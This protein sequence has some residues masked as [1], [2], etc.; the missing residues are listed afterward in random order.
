[1]KNM[2]TVAIQLT[3]VSKKYEI[4][5]EKPT[6]VEKFVKGKNETFWA[7]KD[8]NLTIKKGERVGIIGANG[9][10]KTT[11]L[12]IIAGITT[13]TTGS[14]KTYG[15]V[16]SLIDL[17]AGFHPDLTGYHNIY[18]SG[19]LVGLSKKEIDTKLHT[20]INFADIK[21]FIDAPLFTYSEG[22]K[23]RLGFAVA[24]HADPDILILDEAITVGDSL[25]REKCIKL[26]KQTKNYTLLFTTHEFGLLQRVCEKTLILD[27]GIFLHDQ[28]DL[29][30]QFIQSMPIGE[31][32]VAEA[33]S[34]S[35]YPMITRGD[36]LT[37]QK[38]PFSSIKQGDVIAF[39]PPK[40]T[41]TIVHRVINITSAHGRSTCITKGDN[42]FGLDSW[43][44]NENMYLGTIVK[45]NNKKI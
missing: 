3:N 12:K 36:R 29:Q 18:L 16:V 8:I 2:N 35:M 43:E 15:K 10:G 9:S 19:M 44:V 41:I 1:M 34:Y 31:Q 40:V 39:C 4:H 33:E 20:I 26:L 22:M 17:E 27:K 28:N 45:I 30:I 37:I 38:V 42:V 24:T 6:L 11:L 21:Q 5:H 7:L 23:L 32:C 25:F 13:P 14:V